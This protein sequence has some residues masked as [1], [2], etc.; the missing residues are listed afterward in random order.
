MPG[1][2]SSTKSRIWSVDIPQLAFHSDLVLSALLGISA[3]HLSALNPEDQRVAF[4]AQHYFDRA[5]SQ[6][7]LALGNV[8]HQD[9]EAILA[10]AILI[11]HH[12]WLA[13]NSTPVEEPYVLPLQTYYMARGI[14]VLFDQMWPSLKGSAYLWYAEQGVG[15]DDG[16]PSHFD[17][18]LVGMQQDLDSLSKT[19]DEPDVSPEAKEVYEKTVME[20]SFMCY[21]IINGAEQHHIQSRVATMPIRLPQLFLELVARKDARAL[22]LLARNIALLKVV[23]NI[24]WLHGT[25]KTQQVAEH[26]ITGIRNLIPPE[27]TWTMEWPVQIISGDEKMYERDIIEFGMG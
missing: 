12:T 7:R 14:Q 18:F 1:S 13:S 25:G 3:L 11:C 23:E 17:P 22:A 21:A 16:M 8:E 27:W 19:F 6:H 15:M 4:A 20:I 9:A 26:A 2:Q 24:W 5:V 10:T